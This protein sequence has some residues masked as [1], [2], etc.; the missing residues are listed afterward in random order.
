MNLEF[1]KSIINKTQTP[2]PFQPTGGVSNLV[3]TDL[4]NG[5]CKL[6][7]DLTS[8]YDSY[9]IYR[10]YIP[11]ANFTKIA[12]VQTNTY[13]DTTIKIIPDMD[14][15]YKVVAYNSQTQTEGSKA[16]WGMNN[17]PYDAFVQD[18]FADVVFPETLPDNADVADWFAQI[19]GRNMWMLVS[20]G[21]LMTLLKRR[22][23][24]TRCPDW[25]DE[26][27]QCPKPDRGSIDQKGNQIAPC[28]GTG[29]TFGYYNAIDILVRVGNMP[30]RII[31]LLEQGYR[32]QEEP[33]GWTVW[34]PKISSSDILIDSENNRYQVV[35]PRQTNWRGSPLHQEFDLKK[36]EKNDLLAKVP[37]IYDEEYAPSF[38]SVS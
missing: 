36:V 35:R 29:F 4:R 32:T 24:G 8:G 15:Y 2:T 30:N 11:Y 16:D 28:Y 18:V 21:R 25:S 20:D 37:I 17:L 1:I 10:S 3:I 22:Y 26:D 14:Y 13:T 23:E 19:R 38:S 7:W 27:G 9:N 34:C 33:A 31:D 6:D 5:R 12:T